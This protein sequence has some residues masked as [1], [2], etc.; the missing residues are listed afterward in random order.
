MNKF[1]AAVFAKNTLLSFLLLPVMAHTDLIP[2]SDEALFQ[3]NGQGT[4]AL[5]YTV[6]DYSALSEDFKLELG[7]DSGVPTD[8]AKFSLVG[9]SSSD[10]FENTNGFTIGNANDPFTLT[11]QHE[12]FT[13]AN[14][15]VSEAVSLVYAF[16]TGAYVDD[17]APGV[18]SKFN[19]TT[20]MSM[21]HESGNELHT[22]MSL[23]GV[24]LDNSYY[25]FWVD[26]GKGLSVSGLISLK[27]DT[28]VADAQNTAT[29]QPGTD[30]G[31][32]W[33]VDNL[34]LSFP[35]GATLYQPLNIDVDDEHNLIIELK[36]INLSTAEHFYDTAPKGNLYVDN[37]TMNG[38]ESGAIEIE[39][40]Q[41]QYL[42]VQTRDLL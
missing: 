28:F 30:A 37:I 34:D 16:P 23:Q 8:F 42:R 11:L 15:V 22:W 33:V 27:T 41:L 20:L 38:Y 9:A 2:M 32:Q 36:A 39:G 29:A 5:S 40:I 24:S 7:F 31:S 17:L 3:V 18:D 21:T 12:S 13:D 10:Y 35:L 6:E 26:P 14:D 19:L 4:S 1:I 25:K